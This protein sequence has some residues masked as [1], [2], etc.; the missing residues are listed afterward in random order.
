MSI[1]LFSPSL[2]LSSSS[3]SSSSIHFSFISHPSNLITSLPLPLPLTAFLRSLLLLSLPLG[4]FSLRSLAFPLLSVS[5]IFSPSVWVGSPRVAPSGEWESTKAT[6]TATG[7]VYSKQ[8]WQNKQP[9]NTRDMYGSLL[10]GCLFRVVCVKLNL[11]FSPL[12]LPPLFFPSAISF[13]SSSS[14][15]P[16]LKL[17]FQHVSFL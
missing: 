2:L 13:S 5:L 3:L 15:L 16:P 17:S 10:K 1:F 9:S 6:C 11:I 14:S 8:E 7:G 4:L 12:S